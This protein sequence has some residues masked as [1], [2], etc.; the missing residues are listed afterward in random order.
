MLNM[1]KFRVKKGEIEKIVDEVRTDIFGVFNIP[2][3][4]E[5]EG[6][7]V[8]EEWPE[9]F[10]NKLVSGVKEQLEKPTDLPKIEEMDLNRYKEIVDS[11]KSKAELQA[12]SF[13]FLA[14]KIDQIIK[15]LNP[16]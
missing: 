5:I 8:E 16:K 4:I 12:L 2:D 14:D 10:K 1:T 15:H 3:F 9:S 7:A 11:A 6:E 13:Q